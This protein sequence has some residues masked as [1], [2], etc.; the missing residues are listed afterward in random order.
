MGPEALIVPVTSIAPASVVRVKEVMPLKDVAPSGPQRRADRSVD[1]RRPG[2]NVKAHRLEATEGQRRGQGRR[3]VAAWP[4]VA[5]KTPPVPSAPAVPLTALTV[6]VEVTVVAMDAVPFG[7]E[8][9]SVPAL[10][11]NG[12]AETLTSGGVT[13][14]VVVPVVVTVDVGASMMTSP[15]F[16]VRFTTPPLL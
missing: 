16:E 6:P 8:I 2:Q 9:L 14:P 11:P 10:P 12:E 15:V 4:S 13:V 7:A 1:Y 3:S 5:L